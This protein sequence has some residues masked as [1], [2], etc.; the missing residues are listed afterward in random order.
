MRSS[1]SAYAPRR[2]PSFTEYSLV[3]STAADIEY[4]CS[5]ILDQ[6]H[7]SDYA[8]L[9]PREDEYFS[10]D[11]DEPPVK[12]T[13]GGVRPTHTN[14]KGVTNGDHQNNELE[15]TLSGTGP[16][17]PEPKRVKV[18]EVVAVAGP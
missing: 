4:T 12:G 17:E 16:E 11:E 14:G 9:Q 10:Q 2:S 8:H 7:A 3:H 1:Q 15:R 5:M 13:N 6:I 18:D